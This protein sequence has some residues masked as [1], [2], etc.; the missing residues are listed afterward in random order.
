MQ[1]LLITELPHGNNKV[2]YP[3]SKQYIRKLQFAN[4][5][6]LRDSKGGSLKS[7]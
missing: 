5:Q 6:F 2:R 7:K 3:N 1:G 4:S